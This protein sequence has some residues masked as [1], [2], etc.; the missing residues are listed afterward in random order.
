M[1]LHIQYFAK[2]LSNIN[3]VIIETNLCGTII[4]SI[5]KRTN[6]LLDLISKQIEIET[7]IYPHEIISIIVI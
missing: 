1:K 7:G 4:Y 6:N 3:S 5:D 2:P